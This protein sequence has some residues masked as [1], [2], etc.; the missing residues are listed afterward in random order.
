MTTPFW[1]WPRAIAATRLPPITTTRLLI[2]TRIT[3]LRRRSLRFGYEIVRAI[4]AQIISEGETGH[5]VTDAIGS[6]TLIS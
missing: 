4:D 5:V 3:E 6:R 1:S 2:R